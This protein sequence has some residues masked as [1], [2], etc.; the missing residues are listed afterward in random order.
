MSVLGSVGPNATVVGF[1]AGSLDIYCPPG[2]VGAGHAPGDKGGWGAEEQIRYQRVAETPNHSKHLH[3]GGN[4]VNCLAYMGLQ[5]GVNPQFEG[6]IGVNDPVSAAI[7][8]ELGRFGITNNAVVVPGYLPSVGIIE[9]RAEPGSDRMVRG[10][11]RHPMDEHLS[12]MHLAKAAAAAQLVMVSSLKSA[13]LTHRIFDATPGTAQLSYNPG[14]SEFNRPSGIL[15]AMDH[16]AP[17]LFAAN[18]AELQQL[19]PNIKGA[20]ALARAASRYAEFVL[21]TMGDKGMLLAH[22]GDVIRHRGL[23]VPNERVRDTL[24]AGDRAH[25]VAAHELL[26]VGEDPNTT[27]E[28]VA[29][30]A[31][32]VVQHTGA[33]G[34]LYQYVSPATFSL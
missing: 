2:E 25:A 30:S 6:V 33:H 12:D 17:N 31:A 29:E 18:D 23:H 21:C 16:R 22:N 20:E 5:E 1:G 4:L 24:G 27:L 34:D 19:F 26:I 32:Q 9:R 8:M 10:R 7:R 28:K 15:E 11:P 3:V 14:S 13:P